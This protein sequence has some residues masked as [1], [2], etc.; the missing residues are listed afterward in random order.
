MIY[1]YI[2][3]AIFAIMLA[4]VLWSYKG[5]FE[6]YGGFWTVLRDSAFLSF[7]WPVFL[8]TGLLMI[9]KQSKYEK[10]NAKC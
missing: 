4:F 3:L 2:Y 5:K 1:V 9:Y 10:D 6:K 7:L 8:P